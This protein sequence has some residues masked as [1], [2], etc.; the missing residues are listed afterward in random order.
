MDFGHCLMDKI[1]DDVSKPDP[2]PL[3]T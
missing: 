2:F 3:F 1:G